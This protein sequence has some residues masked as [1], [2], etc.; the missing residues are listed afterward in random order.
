MRVFDWLRKL[1]IDAERHTYLDRPD[2]PLGAIAG[3]VPAVVAAERGLRSLAGSVG[4]STLL[5]SREAS[6][7]SFGLLEAR[8]LRRASHG[9]YDFDDALYAGYPGSLLGRAR[10]IDRV[11]RHAVEAA[12]TVIAGSEHLASHAAKY[13]SDVVTIPSCVDPDEYVVKNTYAVSEHPTVV[14]LGSPS[15]EVH[16]GLVAEPLLALHRDLGLRLT[17]VSAGSRS[18]GEL[19]TMIERI[20]WTPDGFAA[21]LASA[22][23]GIM[24]LADDEWTRGKCAYKLLQYAAAALPVVGSAVGVNVGVLDR[25]G[26]SAARSGAEWRDALDAVLR[27]PE[28]ERARLGRRARDAVIEHYSYGAWAGRWRAAVGV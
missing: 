20:S 4:D 7:L 16:L 2:N 24:P 9:V 1:E 28:S 13:A 6:P 25:L 23:V 27:A 18:H 3:A 15:T 19:D 10:Q 11:W 12:D 17:L 26:G 8:L 5:L 14:W 21:V 22:D